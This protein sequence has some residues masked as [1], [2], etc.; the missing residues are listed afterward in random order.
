MPLRITCLCG[1]TTLELHGRPA[2]RA[3]CHCAT[4]RE[5]YASPMLAA[6]AWAADAVQ[7][8]GAALIRFPHP[9]KQLSKHF[10]QGC[11]DVLFGTNRLGMYVVANAIA[12]RSSGGLLAAPL[13][14]EMHLFYRERIIDV[15]DALPK[16]LEGWDG[17]TLEA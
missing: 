11:G 12:A 9:F 15:A 8:A 4:C 2:A 6:T 1:A 16:Y 10:C 5:F 3:N 17:P 7:V 13:L 14:P